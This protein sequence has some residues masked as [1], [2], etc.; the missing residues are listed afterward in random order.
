[1]AEELFHPTAVKSRV[2]SSRNAR[3]EPSPEH[4]VG[5][6]QAIPDVADQRV[7]KRWIEYLTCQCSPL[8]S[9]H[10]VFE[11]DLIAVSVDKSDL[12]PA[13]LK[14]W[15]FKQPAKSVIDR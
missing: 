6:F 5:I 10:V 9:G 14:G 7:A 4:L 12:L 2:P 13:L 8:P 3:A 11:A 1:M 15:R